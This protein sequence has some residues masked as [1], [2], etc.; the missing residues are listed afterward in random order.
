MTE[1]QPTRA[2]SPLAIP[3]FRMV[4]IASIFSN[5]GGLIQSVGASWLMTSLTHSPTMVA[6]VQAT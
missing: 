6:L 3:A 2:P 1:L 5:F 4:W